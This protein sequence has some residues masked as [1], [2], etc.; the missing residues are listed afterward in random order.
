[1]IMMIMSSSMSIVGNISYV[2]VISDAGLSL[3]LSDISGIRNTLLSPEKKN[4]TWCA[5]HQT[6]TSVKL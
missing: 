4:Y 6:N 2:L 5:V 3:S 1:M